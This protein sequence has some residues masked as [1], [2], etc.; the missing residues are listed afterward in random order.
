M[1]FGGYE[2]VDSSCYEAI[3]LNPDLI[4]YLGESGVPTKL[5][6]DRKEF[7]PPFY[8]CSC[9]FAKFLT[10]TYGLDRMLKAN[11]EFQNEEETI[12]LV[13]GKELQTLREEWIAYLKSNEI[14]K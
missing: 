11:S 5:V 6:T 10:E 4:S 14:K 9:S 2:K 12:K 13:T 8:T 1:G 3:T 7:A